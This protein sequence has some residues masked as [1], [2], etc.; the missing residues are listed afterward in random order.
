[1][2]EADLIDLAVG[3]LMSP[4]N[5][6]AVWQ[7]RPL[8]LGGKLSAAARK[9]PEDGL[10]TA[11][12]DQLSI[13]SSGGLVQHFTMKAEEDLHA[14]AV[15][16]S[17]ATEVPNGADLPSTAMAKLA[18]SILWRRVW[19]KNDHTL[20]DT[21]IHRR[22]LN[23]KLSNCSIT[24]GCIEIPGRDQGHSLHVVATV[25]PLSSDAH[26]I[27]ALVIAL[28]DSLGVRVTL[29]LAASAS[30]DEPTDLMSESLQVSQQ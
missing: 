25:D 4:A 28:R 22:S 23:R 12:L 8:I 29:A 26:K 16:Q 19:K 20:S 13:S 11:L 17:L 3:S 5:M 9:Q 14:E 24:K 30:D 6:I 15:L 21:R 1:M 10:H 18:A 2:H 27:A 7:L